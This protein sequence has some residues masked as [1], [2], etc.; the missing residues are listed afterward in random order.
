[1][2][3][4]RANIEE[5]LIRRCGSLM[6]AVGFSVTASGAGNPNIDLNDPI[7]YGLRKAGFTV[8][9][10]ALVSD[11]DIASITGDA[12]ELD[13]V[14]DIAEYRLL[15]N[16]AGN[17]DDVDIKTGQISESLS[18][19]AAS[20]EKRMARL[21]NKLSSEYGLFVG[22]S[23]LQAGVIGLDFAEHNEQMSTTE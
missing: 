4:T 2:T 9:N 19:L 3:T 14:I 10:I 20:L 12:D 5:I 7:G 8:A 11:A 13:E 23:E 16:I 21:Q 15:E 18:Q 6:T 1:M 17:L 22:G